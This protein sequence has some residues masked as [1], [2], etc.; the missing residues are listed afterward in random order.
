MLFFLMMSRGT[1][2]HTRTTVTWNWY[3]ITS[4]VFECIEFIFNICHWMFATCWLEYFL[5]SK[6]EGIF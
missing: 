1:A 2:M 3:A 4:D 6:L 5:F